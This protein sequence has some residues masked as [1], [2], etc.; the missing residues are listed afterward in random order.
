MGRDQQV[1]LRGSSEDVAFFEL[2]ELTRSAIIDQLVGD[3]VMALYIPALLGSSWE[4]LMLRDARALLEAVGFGPSG[5]PWLT[6]AVGLDVSESC[7]VACPR[8]WRGPP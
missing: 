8:S 1:E 7:A 2:M 6:L 3:E 4:S 5:E